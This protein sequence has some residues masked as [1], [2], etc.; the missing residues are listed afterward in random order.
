MT[1]PRILIADDDRALAAALAFRCRGLGLQV[2]MA[3]DARTALNMLFESP[4]EI[5]C[6]DINMPC[7]NGL[8]VCEMVTGDSRFAGTA[9][10]VMTGN[11]DPQTILRCHSLCA[12]YVPKCVDLWSRIGP[13]LIELLHLPADTSF[14]SRLGP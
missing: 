7:G 5:A 4:P 14:V 13:L 3:H 9:L 8:S 2:Q 12:Y 6:L 1:A 10:I 11:A